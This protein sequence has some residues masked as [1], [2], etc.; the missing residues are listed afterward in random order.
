MLGTLS[1]QAPV[2]AL[3]SLL[4]GLQCLAYALHL[5]RARGDAGALRRRGWSGFF[6]FMGVANLAGVAKHGFRHLLESRPPFLLLALATSSVATGLAIWAAQ[7]ATIRGSAGNDVGRD[8][9]ASAPNALEFLTAGQLTLYLAAN[10]LLGPDMILL[11]GNTVVGL[12][13]VAV[14]EALR[15]RRRGAGPGRGETTAASGSAAVAAGL[16]LSL[17]TGVV[18]LGGLS[19]GAWFNH[20]DVAHALM[21][22]SFY[23]VHR[24]VAGT[25]P[26]PTYPLPSV[27]A[28][29]VHP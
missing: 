22:V 9:P 24:G 21:G 8:R 20:I 23:L 19:V 16:A 5:S 12:G 3:T 4:L 10:L 26:S 14:A 29:G 25:T 27:R 13:P 11:I 17:L 1:V 28:G 18:Y 15:R 7:R 6:F 2:T